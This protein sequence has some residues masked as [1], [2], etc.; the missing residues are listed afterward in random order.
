LRA[1]QD[2]EIKAGCDAVELAKRNPPQL[3]A[4]SMQLRYTGM[5]LPGIGRKEFK[6]KHLL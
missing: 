5:K 2:E 1:P 3:M 6:I 4:R